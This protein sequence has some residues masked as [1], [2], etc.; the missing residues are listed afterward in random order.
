[1]KRIATLLMVALVAACDKP[2]PGPAAPTPGARA[3]EN[4]D[5]MAF[6][7]FEYVPKM[8]LPADIMKHNGNVVRAKGFMNSGRVMRDVTEFE[9]VKDRASCCFGRSPKMNHFFQ[10]KLRAGNKTNYTSDPIT[11]VGKFVVDDRWDG[12][13]QLG[14]Y[15]LEDAII[16]N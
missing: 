4:V 1:M 10:A 5:M 15:W 2:G 16:E 12:D 11:L 13:W 7:A 6:G 14:L 8:V 9:L 3:P